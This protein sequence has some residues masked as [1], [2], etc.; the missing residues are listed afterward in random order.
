M[1]LIVVII[2]ILRSPLLSV[3]GK[4][5]CDGADRSS[6]RGGTENQLGV[7]RHGLL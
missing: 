7:I 6:A 1:G 5:A 4:P 2:M 3:R